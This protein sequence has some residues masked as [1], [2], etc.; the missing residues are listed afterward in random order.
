MSDIAHIGPSW[1]HTQLAKSRHNKQLLQYVY[2]S[3]K[4]WL[5]MMSVSQCL[6]LR[7]CLSSSCFKSQD[8]PDAAVPMAKRPQSAL[9]LC[10]TI[11]MTVTTRLLSRTAGQ[12]RHTNISQIDGDSDPEKQESYT[13]TLPF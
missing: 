6:S 1:N 5:G 3:K 13:F 9:P 7:Y 12:W 4:P 2:A 10:C 11:G 8:S